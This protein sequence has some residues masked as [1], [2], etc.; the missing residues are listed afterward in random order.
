MVFYKWFLN[1]NTFDIIIMFDR[2]FLGCVVYGCLVMYMLTALLSSRCDLKITKRQVF[3]V[4]QYIKSCFSVVM[5]CSMENA[6]YRCKQEVYWDL[7]LL[8]ML[9]SIEINKW[10]EITV[11]MEENCGLK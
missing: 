9:K 10:Y 5:S 4:T 7:F 1:V 8:Y 6:T 3:F 11:A 2:D